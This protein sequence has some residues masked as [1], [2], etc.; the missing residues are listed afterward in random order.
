[1]SLDRLPPSAPAES[2]DQGDFAAIYREYFPLVWRMGRRLGV[3]ESALD[4]V[5]QDVF[6]VVHRRLG[7]FEGRSSLKSWIYGILHNVALVHRRKSSRKG[8]TE[9][10]SLEPD[11]LRSSSATPADAALRQERA[12]LAQSILDE[13]DEDKRIVLILVELEGMSAPDVATALGL[14]VNTVSARLRAARK[15]FAQAV[16]RH[17]ARER[18]RTHG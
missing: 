2:V 13:L 11:E 8:A 12:N 17:R 15:E 14:N 18:W 9:H 3:A 10:P 7:D 16:A 5:C 6:V 4:D 1:M